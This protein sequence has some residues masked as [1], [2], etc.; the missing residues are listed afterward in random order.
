M[1][2]KSRRKG[3]DRSAQI[4]DTTIQQLI[5]RGLAETSTR[6]VAKEA[7]IG[8]GLINHYFTWSHLR[9]KAWLAIFDRVTTA[10]INPGTAADKAM[11]HF[12]EQAFSIDSEP[13]WRLWLGAINLA[14]KDE[15]MAQVLRQI[16]KS[17]ID[18]LAAILEKGAEQHGW[19]ISDSRASAQLLYAAHDGLSGML[20][21]NGS[22][23]SPTQAKERLRHLF[24]MET[25]QHPF[26]TGG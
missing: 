13:L 22:G 17:M 24:V 26:S 25:G 7:G 15:A 9:A 11:D 10:L 2:G 6:S 12:I 16:Q 5:E 14:N 18:R 4:I 23:L 3:E 19:Q 21:V 1:K 8:A 20:M